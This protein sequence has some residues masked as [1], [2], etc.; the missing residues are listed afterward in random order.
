MCHIH[1]GRYVSLFAPGKTDYT[2][3]HL[4]KTTTYIS[5]IVPITTCT[6]VKRISIGTQKQRKKKRVG[7]KRKERKRKER[8]RKERKGKE[9]KGKE[10]KGK[11]RKGKERKGKEKNEHEKGMEI[12][13]IQEN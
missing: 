8:K 9:R 7:R 11:E 3:C 1:A 10:R 12:R 6:R 13:A 5:H 4:R 2:D